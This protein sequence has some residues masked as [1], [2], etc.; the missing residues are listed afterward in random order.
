MIKRKDLLKA[1]FDNDLPA[2][3]D[4][5][6]P[7]ALTSASRV[8][9]GAVRAMGLSLG[10][11]EETAAKAEALTEQLSRGEM[12]HDLDP[13]LVEP[14][15]VD[16]RIDRTADLDFRRLVD[17]ISQVGQHVPI[18][19]RPH[20]QEPGHYQ[21]AYGHR[22]LSACRELS[23]PVKAL[24]RPLTDHEL[25]VAQGNENAER[26]NLSFIERALFAHHLETKGFDRPTIQS[27]LSVHPA[28]MTRLLA[29]VRTIPADVIAAIGPAPRAG[30]P[31]WMEFAVLREKPSNA[32]LV[33]TL[34]AQPSFRQLGSD[35]RFDL[36]I[37]RLRSRPTAQSFTIIQ[38]G[39]GRPAVKA[40]HH[41]G[42]FRLMIDLKLT[43]GLDQF[44]LDRLPVLLASFPGD[45]E[46]V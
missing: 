37:E 17:S 26:R 35:S 21:V 45:S 4:G 9:S 36:L 8:P 24:I 18:L 19:V 7:A 16:D 13:L 5:Q 44:L 46:A 39:V 14:S 38:D 11:I 40:D 10:R 25:V 15:F 30:R 32:A 34:L 31:R 22:R 29:V 20:P 2:P 43:P 1:A 42:G 3:S 6:Y 33:S 12:L 23:R 41:A 27:A 28:E